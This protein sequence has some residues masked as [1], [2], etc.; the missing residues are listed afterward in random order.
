MTSVAIGWIGIGL[1]IILL[2][3]GMPLGPAMALIGFLGYWKIS[4][5]GPALAAQG[6]IPYASTAVYSQSVIPLFIIMGYFASYAGFAG[7]LFNAARRWVGWLPGGMVQTTIA[8]A[9]VFGAA[10]GSGM[11]SCAILSKLT[12]PEMLKQGVQRELAFGVVAASGSIAAMIPPSVLM[13]IYG[14]ITGVSIG[15]LL[16]SG[17]IP[18]I[19][20]AAIFMIWTHVRLAINPS[21]SPKA[22]ES[23]S[24][25]ERFLS[26]R[27][28]W[29]VLIM[30][31]VVLGG[32]YAGVFTPTEAGAAGAVWVFL[33]SLAL[34][35]LGW[36]SLKDSLLETAK[37]TGTIFLIIIG[38]AIFGAFI[39]IS[40]IPFELSRALSTANVPPMVIIIGIMIL[41]IILGTFMDVFALLLLTIP[42][43]FPVIMALGFNPI[44][45][46]VLCVH[47]LAIG[48]ITPPYG[49]HL[50]IIK[51]AVP[52]SHL[53][54]IIRGVIPF[55]WAELVILAIYLAF[56]QLSLFL[57]SLMK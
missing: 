31:V 32:I 10:C 26:L 9:T 55:I 43:F 54:E 8:G 40:N 5:L 2:L 27:G 51:A 21:L 16:I 46:G 14:S 57:P 3:I 15:K 45:F 13:V 35:R 19:V 11:A 28:T 18:G 33:V 6:I 47:V 39:T 25:K 4:G 44:W 38:G 36:K 53:S 1:F 17:V 7:D 24:W 37:T 30:V 56:P 22:M 23:Y 41:Y 29:G 12:I 42:I 49:I 50:F 20:A 52:Q 48:V 34:R